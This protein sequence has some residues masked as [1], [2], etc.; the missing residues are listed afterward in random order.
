SRSVPAGA[1]VGPDVAG[2]APTEQGRGELPARARAERRAHRGGGRGH[3]DTL[4]RGDESLEAVARA[5]RSTRRISGHGAQLSHGADAGRAG[6]GAFMKRTTKLAGAGLALLFF[7]VAPG[8]KE[9]RRAPPSESRESPALLSARSAWRA[10][11]DQM[12]RS[13][14]S[15]LSR[16]DFVHL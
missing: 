7:G 3:L 6:G 12:M 15:P 8:C 5:H 11:Q 1:E 2:Q 13:E 9:P 4:C 14:L 16:I 10:K